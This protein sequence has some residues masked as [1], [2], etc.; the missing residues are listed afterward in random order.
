M[1]EPELGF[2]I[3][4]ADYRWG[5]TPGD[6]S[7]IGPVPV[8]IDYLHLDV[9]C[10]AALG[11][12]IAGMTLSTPASDRPVMNVLYELEA[13]AAGRAEPA[14]WMDGLRAR[15]GPPDQE[16][17]EDQHDSSSVAYW[18]SWSRPTIEIGLSIY[19]DVRSSAF[20]RSA[21]LVYVRWL[22]TATAA[23]PYVAQWRASTAALVQS[24]ATL[25]AFHRF[26]MTRGLAP[27]GDPIDP[28]PAAFEDWRALNSRTLLGTPASIVERLSAGSC[29]LWQST[30]NSLWAFSTSWDTVVLR[31]TS[32]ASW[33]EIKPAKGGGQSGLSVD[34]LSIVMPYG[35]KGIAAA[36]AALKALPGL[37]V[38]KT[39]DYDV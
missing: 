39:E 18:A 36:A 10:R 23:A 29:A 13:P 1:I 14:H 20:G 24:A 7:R 6:I 31:P 3:D 17:E 15:F 30:E 22:D 27:A 38:A 35:T 37:K 34:D 25:A 8:S 11:F 32:R 16:E 9:P 21:G 4:D 19:G 26:D 12:R 2:A 5:A 33:T 28:H